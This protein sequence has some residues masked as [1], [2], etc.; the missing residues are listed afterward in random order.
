MRVLTYYARQPLPE[1]ACARR[2]IV[3]RNR[4]LM[5]LLY[6]TGMRI[7]EALALSREDVLDGRALKVRLVRTKNG[8]PR[9]VFCLCRYTRDAPILYPRAQRQPLC[10]VVHLSRA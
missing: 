5:A 8:K 3:L 10:A 9:T 4:A 6:D 2:L 7:S 1:T